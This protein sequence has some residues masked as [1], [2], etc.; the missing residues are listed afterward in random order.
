MDTFKHYDLIT[1]LEVAELNSRSIEDLGAKTIKTKL[2]RERE[3]KR[4]GQV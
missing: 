4:G 2:N 3:K 1:S